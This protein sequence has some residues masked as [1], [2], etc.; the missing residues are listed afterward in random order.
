[1]YIYGCIFMYLCVCIHPFFEYTIFKYIYIHTHI[2]L[3]EN[4][5]HKKSCKTDFLLDSI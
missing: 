3:R 1:M 2:Q 5:T 4:S